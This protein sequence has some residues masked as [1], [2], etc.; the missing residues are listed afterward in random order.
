MTTTEPLTE[1]EQRALQQMHEAQVGRQSSSWLC[2]TKNTSFAALIARVWK[3][4]LSR[5]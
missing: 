1:R 3:K 2:A 4:M 5:S